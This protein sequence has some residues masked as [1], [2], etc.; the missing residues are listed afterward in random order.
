MIEA[1]QGGPAGAAP[2][3]YAPDSFGGQ[4]ETRDAADGMRMMR[5]KLG[6]GNHSRYLLA[7][8]YVQKFL[9]TS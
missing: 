1:H 5:M 7:E 4:T 3:E 9:L 2:D 8:S 6:K